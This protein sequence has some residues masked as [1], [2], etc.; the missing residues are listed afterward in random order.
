MWTASFN[1]FREIAEQDH[2]WKL[3]REKLESL[4]KKNSAIVT[5]NNEEREVKKIFPGNPEDTW[6][7]LSLIFFN[8]VMIMYF[9]PS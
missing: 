8:L 5:S 7:Y 2:Q 3:F 4:R 1:C 6:D 9:L